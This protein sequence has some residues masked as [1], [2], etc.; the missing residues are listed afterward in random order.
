MEQFSTPTDDV[1]VEL[2]LCSQ[3]SAYDLSL[4]EAFFLGRNVSTKRSMFAI[5]EF[6]MWALTSNYI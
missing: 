3:N 4:S 1:G 5:F 6:L 2:L